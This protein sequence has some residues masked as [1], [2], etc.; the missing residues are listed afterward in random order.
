MA[1]DI[2]G[3]MYVTIKHFKNPDTGIKKWFSKLTC[4]LQS[5]ERRCVMDF[6]IIFRA[7]HFPVTIQI[8]K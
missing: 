4:V 8:R 6:N 3:L 1:T 5:F 7:E 2:F